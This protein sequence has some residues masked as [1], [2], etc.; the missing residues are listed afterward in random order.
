MST[1]Q[2]NIPSN[3]MG[4]I[5][6]IGNFDGVHRGHQSMLLR[7]RDVAH[8]VGGPVVIVTFDPHP[9]RI[10][11]PEINLP[12]LT[13]MEDRSRLLQ[14]HG[15]DAVVVLP[16]SDSLLAMAPDKFFHTVIVDQLQA[17]GMVEGPDFRFGR[18][19]AGNIEM[20]SSLC[21]EA[22]IRLTVIDEVTESSEMISSSRIRECIAAGDVSGAAELLGRPPFVSGTVIRGDGRGRG[23]GFPTA[24]L[25]IR[26]VLIPPDGVY[27]GRA[28]I[29]NRRIPVA[30]SVGSNPTFQSTERRIECHLIDYDGDLYDRTLSVDFLQRIRS[31][32]PFKTVEEL[33]EAIATDVE[34]CRRITAA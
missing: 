26:D 16:V 10:L 27:A 19:R 15:A 6:A 9:V 20:L 28:Q 34:I 22:K 29:A 8:E 33:K 31:L 11:S 2:L 5:V 12:V 25:E 24:N 13:L 17:R 32:T 30:I 14:Q 7:A 1:L 3:A 18:N 4:G 23:L 21:S